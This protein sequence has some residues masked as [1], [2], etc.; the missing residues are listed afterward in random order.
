MN[1]QPMDFASFMSKDFAAV[2]PFHK[3]PILMTS[4]GVI[5][6]TMTILRYIARKTG[7]LLGKNEFESALIEQ[8][9]EYANSE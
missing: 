1:V 6:E 3:C 4:E 7:K 8:W 2:Y 5:S 9:L